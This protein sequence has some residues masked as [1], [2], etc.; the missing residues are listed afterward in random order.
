MKKI[1]TDNF[2]A[3]D[4]IVKSVFAGDVKIRNENT[5]LCVN[6]ESLR[7]STADF[8][9]ILQD[10][11][12]QV[13]NKHTKESIAL[14]MVLTKR[15]IGYAEQAKKIGEIFKEQIEEDLKRAL[16]GFTDDSLLKSISYILTGEIE[17]FDIATSVNSAKTDFIRMKTATDDKAYVFEKVLSKRNFE[18]NK[19]KYCMAIAGD[20][21]LLNK[22]LKDSFITIGELKETLGDFFMILIERKGA[23]HLIKYLDT[24][25]KIKLYNEGFIN[26]NE[27]AKDKLAEIAYN[28]VLALD[29]KS[30]IKIFTANKKY[31]NKEELNCAIWYL[32]EKGFF[33]ID[34]INELIRFRAF[35]P[36]FPISTYMEY[37]QRKIRAEIEKNPVSEEKIVEYMD[38][39]RAIKMFE[40]EHTPC[41]NKE[42]IKNELNSIYESQNKSFSEAIIKQKQK[43]AKE[44]NQE[45]PDYISLYEE[46]LIGLDSLPDGAI[47]AEDIISIYIE[48]GDNGAL[49]NGYN[50]GIVG[51]EDIYEL[52][53]ENDDELCKLITNFN[54]NPNVL[55]YFY[56]TY[57]ILKFY[58]EKKISAKCLMELKSKNDL[59]IKEVKKL[60]ILKKISLDLLEDLTENGVLTEEQEMDIKN[61][62]DIK[63]DYEKLVQIGEVVSLDNLQEHRL[64]QTQPKPTIKHASR[65]NGTP[66]FPDK[67]GRSTRETLL[68]LLGA[69]PEKLPVSG[70]LFAGYHMYTILEHETA[71]LEPDNGRAKTFI[72]PLRMVLEQVDAK[73]NDILS[74][75]KYKRDIENDPKVKTAIHT[76]KWGR[77]VVRGMSELS[78]LFKQTN[79]LKD[80]KYITVLNKIENN[81]RQ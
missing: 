13:S 58:T 28:A 43:E 37:S 52:V 41:A 5:E 51:I 80:N 75:A 18:N 21:K 10:V 42:F 22:L 60:Y 16:V 27:F 69:E 66:K 25:Q 33:T 68:N 59:S 74:T 3:K 39:K 11:I 4:M 77:S 1:S 17:K 24:E 44:K 23:K 32:F 64:E 53:G 40:D 12:I 36:N 30:T 29:S 71:I 72:L 2:R 54:L 70:E 65:G 7:I 9:F 62:Y 6:N 79:P 63:A 15:A 34:D 20:E 26:E 14:L 76:A 73:G 45:R 78:D 67:I 61:A 55:T 19:L 49:V 38:A 48:K 31:Y 8:L 81:Y 50:S 56:S 47:T 46:G 57:Q 35:D